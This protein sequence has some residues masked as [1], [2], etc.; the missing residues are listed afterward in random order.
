MKL[1]HNLE[2]IKY[3]YYY[4]EI[5]L[6]EKINTRKVIWDWDSFT[7][8]PSAIHIIEHN[9]KRISK[10]NLLKNN[11]AIYLLEKNIDDYILYTIGLSQNPSCVDLLLKNTR[12]IN[13]IGLSRNQH[14]K[15]IN[16]LFYSS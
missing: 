9:L 16:L 15:M 4:K 2:M 14:T 12:L 3:N 10:E 11:N 6:L 7:M 8:N 13:I 5:R 1:I